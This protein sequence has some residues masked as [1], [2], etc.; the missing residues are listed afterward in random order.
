MDQH[1]FKYIFTHRL[2]FF[3]GLLIFIFLIL[4]IKIFYLQIIKFENYSTLAKNN[5]LKILPIP[6]IRGQILDVNGKVLAEN[7]LVYT[8]EINP[9]DRPNLNKIKERLTSIVKDRKSVV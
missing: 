8:L 3:F 7:K 6:P 1:K 4:L 2:N 9:K 5:S